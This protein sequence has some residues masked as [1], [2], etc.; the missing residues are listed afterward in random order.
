MTDVVKILAARKA[1]ALRAQEEAA[2]EAA[3]IDR[4]LQELAR[5]T[6]KYGLAESVE[7]DSTGSNSPAKAAPTEPS[8]TDSYTSM[9][10]RARSAASLI[11]R[12]MN[13]PVPLGQL[14]D[15]LVQRGVILNGKNPTWVLSALLGRSGFKSIPGRGWWLPE[16]GDPPTPGLRDFYDKTYPSEV[17]H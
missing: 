7:R 6:E 8:V 16:L 14:Y 12:D 11:I 2:R 5:I 4:D 9:T 10:M 17:E 13:R 1:A 15:R 3:E